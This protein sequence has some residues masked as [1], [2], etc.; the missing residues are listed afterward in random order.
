M[1]ASYEYVTLHGRRDFEDVIKVESLEIE[2]YPGFS[3]EIQY[4]HM[5]P[6]KQTARDRAQ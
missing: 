3:E 1:T 4:K 2:D 6:T 5:S